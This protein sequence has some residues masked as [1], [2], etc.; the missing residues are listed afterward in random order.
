MI[1]LINLEQTELIHTSDILKLF[2]KEEVVNEKWGKS[3]WNS[4]N[5]IQILNEDKYKN[6]SKFNKMKCQD[7]FDW[8][9]KVSQIPV[10]KYGRNNMPHQIDELHLHSNHNFAVEAH[11]HKHAHSEEHRR[12]INEK[13]IN[14]KFNTISDNSK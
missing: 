11:S 7:I 13:W 10:L 8:E 4:D 1:F 3:I 14:K 2:S 9:D 6:Y 5:K 12:L